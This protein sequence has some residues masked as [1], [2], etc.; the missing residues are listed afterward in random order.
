MINSNT[1]LKEY[2]ILMELTTITDVPR[3]PSPD[4]LKE[5]GNK[6]EQYAR[7]LN[8]FDHL[9]DINILRNENA[10][11]YDLLI[12]ILYGQSIY[13]KNFLAGYGFSN[14]GGTVSVT[15]R[16]P[17]T[18]CLT[19]LDLNMSDVRN[20]QK[21]LGICTDENFNVTLREAL[22][23]IHNYCQENT[24]TFSHLTPYIVQAASRLNN[25]Y[26]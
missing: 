19:S 3:K 14:W 11:A 12:L 25:I 15:T 5:L 18:N 13:S 9:K 26:S 1:L 20:F 7:A 22:I 6:W 21:L 24:D 17:R 8:E 10:Q 16:S 23:K 2:Q 4:K